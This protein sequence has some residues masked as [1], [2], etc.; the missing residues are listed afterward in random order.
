MDARTIL[1]VDDEPLVRWLVREVLVLEGYEVLEA[2]SGEEA[3]RC[4]ERHGGLVHLLLADVRMPGMTGPEL[5][6]RVIAARPGIKV[7]YMS[8]YSDREDL[9][10]RLAAQGAGFL[11]KPFFPETLAEKVRELLQA[12]AAPMPARSSAIV[13]ALS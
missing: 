8:G 1:L 6:D 13:G 4:L 2:G 11:Q 7:L 10:S 12:P 3:L 9:P 5:V